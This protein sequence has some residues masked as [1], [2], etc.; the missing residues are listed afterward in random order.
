MVTSCAAAA[1]G[2]DIPTEPPPI[3]VAVVTPLFVPGHLFN[4]SDQYV[5]GATGDAWAMGDGVF[6]EDISLAESLDPAFGF[7]FSLYSQN[8]GNPAITVELFVETD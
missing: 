7:A 6:S 1:L 3:S 2:A 5:V 4:V 8:G